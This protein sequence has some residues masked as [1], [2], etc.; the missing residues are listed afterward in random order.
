MDSPWTSGALELL[1]HAD[2]HSVLDTAFDKRIAY[3][4]IDN[5]VESMVHTFLTMPES[6]SG[7]S[8]T[9]RELEEANRSFPKLLGLLFNKVGSILTG[10]DSGDIEH[11]HR[12]RNT[13]YHNGTG[14]SVDQQY[15]AAYRSIASILLENLFGIEST[16]LDTKRSELEQLILD[17]NTLD[18]C[19]HKKMK[20]AGIPYGHT[21]KW[22]MAFEAGILTPEQMEKLTDLRMARN[23]VV[24]SDSI[25]HEGVSFWASRASELL[26]DLV[27]NPNSLTSCT[28]GE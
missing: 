3:I 2:S 17:W 14:L 13:L 25:D 24:H 5:A 28:Y 22:E 9:R 15:L 20:E 26:K 27:N 8:V 11:Y 21:Y 4:S 23:K 16:P 18:K 6:A 1:G 10:I 12:I 7:V 19:L